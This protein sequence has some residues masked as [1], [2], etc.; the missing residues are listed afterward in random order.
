MPLV[1]MLIQETIHAFGFVALAIWII[2]DPYFPIDF[3]SPVTEIGVFIV[4]TAGVLL[5]VHIGLKR[6]LSRA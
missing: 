4:L 2:I 5:V 3:E 1:Q 6:L